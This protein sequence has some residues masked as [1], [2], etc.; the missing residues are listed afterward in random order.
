AYES[1]STSGLDS[2]GFSVLSFWNNEIDCFEETL[3]DNIMQ[4]L[5]R[6]SPSP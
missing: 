5:N 4:E 1:R 2:Q 6:R 3:L